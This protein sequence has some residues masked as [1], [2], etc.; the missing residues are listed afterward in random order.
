MEQEILDPLEEYTSRFAP[1]FKEICEQTFNEMAAEAKVDLAANRETCRKVYG[2]EEQLK[3]TNKLL[4]RW[5]ALS[6]TLWIV[7]VIGLLIVIFGWSSFEIWISILIIAA[8]AGAIVGIFV[9]VRPRIKQLE[10]ESSDAQQTIK[11]L[12]DEAWKQMEPLNKLYDW[13]TFAHMMSR[14]LPN[15]E[16]DPYFTTQR[17]ADLQHV[18]GW[19]GD[20]NSGRSVLYSHSGLINGNPFVICRTRKMEWGTKTYYGELTIHWTTTER[21]SDG[22]LYT[23]EH[24]ETLRADYT[25]PYPKY[26]ELTRLIYGNTAAPD[27]TFDREH[28][29]LASKE[30]S[31]AWKWKKHKLNKQANDL[32][33][34]DFAMLTNEEFEVAF[35]TH[36]RNNNHQFALLFTPLAQQNIMALLTDEETG[37]GDDFDFHKNHMINTV[38]AKHMQLMDL[39]MNP[40]QFF[41]FDYDKAV[42]C[43][44]STNA[45]YFRAIYFN[46]APLLCVELYQYIRPVSEIYG[47]DM[48]QESSFWE[49]ESLA[50]A[51][52]VENF[53]APDCVTNCILKTDQ[54]RNA[55]GSSTIHVSAYGYRTEPRVTYIPV[56]GGDGRTHQVPVEWEEYLPVTGEGEIL[57][58][59][60]NQQVPTDATHT[61]HTEHINQM[62]E[63]C[64]MQ[65]YRRHIASSLR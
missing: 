5:K 41:H 2:T 18:Y 34:S 65:R 27:L 39:D 8:I 53:R 21:G 29:G 38:V 1:R 63:G 19:S 7:A 31:L 40:Q 13:D 22:K 20:F 44:K 37:Y 57:M 47:R 26:P 3:Q 62:L 30:G 45:E 10:K 23:K 11:D 49:H 43:F 46:L 60:D 52:G 9:K 59:E 48:M 15:M 61:E 4:S 56:R 35:D 54:E 42:E 51:W 6:W 28:S 25:A 58:K 17:L 12:K 14:T 16:F 33:K 36:N 24:S 55:D 32:K 50:N 64:G